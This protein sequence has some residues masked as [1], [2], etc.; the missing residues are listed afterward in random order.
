MTDDVQNR[1]G[2][3]LNSRPG[4]QELV[5]EFKALLAEAA[6]RGYQ[7]SDGPRVI[8]EWMKFRRQFE[9]QEMTAVLD[10]LYPPEIDGPD[11]LGEE[12]MPT[13][14]LDAM[15]GIDW[16]DPRLKGISGPPLGND[17]EG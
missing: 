1:P 8:G 6:R 7:P 12:F 15:L 3:I 2:V 5:A 4:R 17:G 9:G 10:H 11:G 16:D 13:P 14:N